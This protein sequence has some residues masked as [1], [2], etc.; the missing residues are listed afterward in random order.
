MSGTL[1]PSPWF[2]FFEDTG[3]PLAGGKLYTYTAGTTTLAA[4]YSD[5]ALATPN[6]NPIILDSAGRCGGIYLPAAS[7]KYK[8][9]YSNDALFRTQDNIPAT[10]L[11][12]AVTGAPVYFMG[13]DPNSPV[14]DTSYPSGTT[15]D[16]CAAGTAWQ[17]I[18]SSNLVGTF[19]IEG[20]LLASGGTVSVALVNLTD[21]SPDTPLA[22]ISSTSSTGER[23]RSSTITFATGG[24][25]KTYA[26]KTKVSAGYGFQWDAAIVRTS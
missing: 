3:A 7:F 21:G 12:S 19:A 9:Y 14:T 16:K 10:G 1:S 22:T 24:A 26:L 15:F 5:F 17:S 4:T 6:A 11:S 25:A 23:Q 8:L 18:D 2:T 20:M 13:G